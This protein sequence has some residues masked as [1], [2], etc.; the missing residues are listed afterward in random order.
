MH[1]PIA[2]GED[3]SEKHCLDLQS[4]V[5]N[6]ASNPSLNLPQSELG[7]IDADREEFQVLV[8]EKERTR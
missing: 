1:M 5:G 2:S 4:L 7:T 6:T 3:S 8:C